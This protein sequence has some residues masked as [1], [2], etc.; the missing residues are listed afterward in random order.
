MGAPEERAS[1]QGGRTLHDVVVPAVGE[2]AILAAH[3][4]ATQVH[5]VRLA[6][7]ELDELAQPREELCVPVGAVLI[8]QDGELAV[9]LR[10]GEGMAAPAPRPPPAAPRLRPT[11]PRGPD[12]A[13]GQ[14][15]GD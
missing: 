15:Q 1:G 13:G 14:G 7:L 2:L 8:G 3:V 5:L 6:V 12:A 4:Q 11:G 9:A 10:G